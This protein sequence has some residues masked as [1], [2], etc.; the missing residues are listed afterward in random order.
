MVGDLIG[1][2]LDHL[3]RLLDLHRLLRRSDH[4]LGRCTHRACNHL[5]LPHHHLPA[6]LQGELLLLRQEDV[7]ASS[8]HHQSLPSSVRTG[9]QL[10]HCGRRPPHRLTHAV[11]GKGD[12]LTSH[13]LVLYNLELLAWVDHLELRLAGHLTSKGELALRDQL[14][15]AALSRYRVDKLD[16]STVA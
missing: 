2:H 15:L 16:A 14:E 4:H 13:R 8:L 9:H 3:E 5:L 12:R 10:G 1:R 11:D 6:L 7:A